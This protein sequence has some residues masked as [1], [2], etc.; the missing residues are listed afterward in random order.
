MPPYGGVA[1]NIYLKHLPVKPSF[2][3]NRSGKAANL[4]SPIF[5]PFHEL[6]YYLGIEFEYPF[7]EEMLAF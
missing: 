4:Q 2:T 3:A 7:G 6:P 5:S 1:S